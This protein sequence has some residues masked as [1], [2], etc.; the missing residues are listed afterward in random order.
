LSSF[1]HPWN[2]SGILFG[3]KSLEYFFVSNFIPSTIHSA[4]L[5]GILFFIYL[6]IY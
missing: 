1:S 2:N 5:T 4:G 3:I 6:F